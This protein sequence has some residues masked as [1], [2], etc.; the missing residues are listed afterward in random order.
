MKKKGLAGNYVSV[1]FFFVLDPVSANNT[2]SG[3]MKY[4]V[5]ALYKHLFIRQAFRQYQLSESHIS[6]RGENAFPYLPYLLTDS[7]EI[8]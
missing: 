1:S 5:R 6:P 7:D 3:F 4:F 2:L 8:C